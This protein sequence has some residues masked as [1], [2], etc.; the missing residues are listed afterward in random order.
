MYDHS[1][2]AATQ[3]RPRSECLVST[4]KSIDLHIERLMKISHSLDRFGDQLAGSPPKD[5]RQ[6]DANGM[7]SPQGLLPAL[8]FRNKTVS[9]LLSEIEDRCSRIA[10]AID[11]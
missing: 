1:G 2:T 5:P 10:T 7:A 9:S 8:Q 6:G 4:V 3:E 11:G